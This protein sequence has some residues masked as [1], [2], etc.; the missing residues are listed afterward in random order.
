MA[1]FS[2][3]DRVVL[4]TGANSGIGQAT[5]IAF[6]TYGAKVAVNF[7]HNQKGAEKT[8]ERIQQRG[9]VAEAF[10]AD[11]TDSSQVSKMVG[12]VL[13]RFG[14]RL[15]ILVNN[16]G[17]WMPKTP[18]EECPE[19]LW[20]EMMAVNLKGVFLCCRA[21]I[22]I[23]KRQKEGVIVNVSS[24]AGHTGGGGGTLPYAAAKGGVN[25]LTRGL[26]RELAPWGIRVNAVAPGIVETPMQRQFTSPEDLQGWAEKIPLRR[27]GIPEDIVGAILFLASPF[28]AYITGEI[29]EVNGGLLM[30]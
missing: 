12:S 22:P 21:V 20:D 4:V 26:A 13:E 10:Q 2:F 23:M 28:A 17:R 14:G 1:I 19:E 30:R 8:V 16:A 24:I 15:D 11:V 9:G 5:A 27:L 3:A 6:A 7:C 25:A 18:L 29:I